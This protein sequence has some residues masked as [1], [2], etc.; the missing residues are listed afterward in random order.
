MLAAVAAGPGHP[1]VAALL[2]LGASGLA[3]AV[4]AMAWNVNARQIRLAGQLARRQSLI[5][6]DAGRSSHTANGTSGINGSNGISGAYSSGSPELAPNEAVAVASG[7][8]RA[9]SGGGSGA[10][11]GGGSRAPAGGG[12]KAP[13]VIDGPDTVITGEPVRYRVEP[14]AGRKVVSWAVGGGSVSQAPDPAHPEELLLTADQPGNLTVIVRVREGMTERRATLPVAAVAEVEPPAPPLTLRLFLQ[15]WGLIVVAILAIGL[16]GALDALGSLT[17]S[18]FI[19]LVV[20]LTA[21]LGFAA[22]ARG[23]D[24]PPGRAGTGPAAARRRLLPAVTGWAGWAGWAGSAGRAGRRRGHALDPVGHREDVGLAGKNLLHQD[25]VHLKIGIQAAVGQHGQPVVQ[26]GALAQGRQDHP[27]GG[28]AGQHQVLGSARPQHHI[29][30]AAGE[31]GHPALDHDHIL[32]GR[33]NRRVNAGPGIAFGEPAGFGDAREALVALADLRI[34][35]AEPDDHIDDRDPGAARGFDRPGQPGQVLLVVGEL[36]HGIHDAVLQVHDKQGGG[37][38]EP[39]FS[40]GHAGVV[41]ILAGI[42]L[43]RLPQLVRPPRTRFAGHVR[44]ST[45]VSE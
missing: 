38:H 6:P 33:G 39:T 34:T 23:T 37:G 44:P 7:G 10:P 21:L 28:D 1:A 43:S 26:V 8:S 27:A 11:S 41:A 14:S 30:V 17:A 9:P 24:D 5:A 4:V 13:V 22:V 36:L 35:R 3:G 25:L 16:A 12:A 31:R 19:A 2:G 45:G 18:D 29:Q 32:V 20:P 42:R 40:P 15:G